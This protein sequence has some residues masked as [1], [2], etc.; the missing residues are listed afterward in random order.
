MKNIRKSLLPAFRFL[1]FVILSAFVLSFTAKAQTREFTTI[2]PPGARA[3]V[4]YGIN[5]RGEI[6]G[7]YVDQDFVQHGFLYS[8]GQ[9]TVIDVPG[10]EGTIAR[11]IGPNG[12]IVGEYWLPGDPPIAGR[13]FLRTRRGEYV[14]VK[15]PGHAWEF[16]QRILPDGT[17]L[18]CRH[19]TD[20][21]S[22]MRGAMIGKHGTSET[23][24]FGSMHNGATPDRRLI[25][26]LWFNMMD[27]QTQG[28]TIED[29][30]FNSFIVPG[31]NLT[32]AWDVNP[33]GVIV[34]VFRVGTT[35]RGFVRTGETYETIHYPGS[36]VTRTFGINARGDI[37][38]AYVTMGVTYA[39]LGR[40]VED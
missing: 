5:A 6:V 28:Y 4:A 7:T 1:V 23:D 15:Y 29:G 2:A 16:L 27:N 10:A 36:A 8:K 33:D 14:N 11:G 25:V 38:G 26:G 35:V 22:T 19:D 9:F 21:M 39:Y 40:V 17:I 31:S 20:L 24:A 34:G 3:S 32:S 30:V 12:E 37:V 13:G 18:G